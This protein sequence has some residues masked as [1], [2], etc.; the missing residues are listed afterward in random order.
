M[1]NYLVKN[2]SNGLKTCFQIK[3]KIQNNSYKSNF[4]NIK[5]KNFRDGEII[6]DLY[7]IGFERGLC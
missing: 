5:I 3:K 2:M 7:I 6:P 4:V 1:C